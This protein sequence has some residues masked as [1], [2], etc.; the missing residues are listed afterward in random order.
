MKT[1]FRI[2]RTWYVM[3]EGRACAEGMYIPL[4]CEPTEELEE[5]TSVDADWRD[6][7]PEG[8]DDDRTCGQILKEQK[9]SCR[10]L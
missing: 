8:G 1:L 7:I 5:A 4:T 6:A 9:E 3:A 2:Q 10:G